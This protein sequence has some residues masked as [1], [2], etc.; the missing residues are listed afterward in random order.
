MAYGLLRLF[1]EVDRQHTSEPRGTLRDLCRILR[2]DRHVIEISVRQAKGVTFREFKKCKL[3][4]T[5]VTFLNDNP[6]VSIKHI[7]LTMGFRR[8]SW[9]SFRVRGRGL[10]ATEGCDRWRDLALGCPVVAL[11]ARE[12][13]RLALAR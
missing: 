9:H 4:E 1:N 10:L 6:D 11:Q 12:C 2:V 8:R 7:A 3:L 13:K 5:S